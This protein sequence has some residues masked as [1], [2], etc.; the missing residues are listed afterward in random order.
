MRSNKFLIRKAIEHDL[1]FVMSMIKSCTE[2][3]IS[4]HIFQWNEKYPNSG[5]FLEDIYNEHLYVLISNNKEIIGCVSI[6]YEMDDFYKNIDWISPSNKNIYVHR[7]AVHPNHQGQGYAKKI[8]KFIEEKGIKN[9]CESIRLDTFSM[10]K[11][12]NALYKKIGYEKLG[13][14]Y[15]RDQSELPFN[16]YEKPLKQPIEFCKN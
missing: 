3:M 11:R 6:T 13:Q 1:I 8:M 10:N 14:I 5:V 15:F 12:N 7:L 16:C 4:N 2:N 9:M